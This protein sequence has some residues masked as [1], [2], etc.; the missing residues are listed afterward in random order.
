[1]TRQSYLPTE[2]HWG[3]MFVNIIRQAGRGTTQ[4]SIDLARFHEVEPMDMLTLMPP[5]RVSRAVVLG[6]ARRVPCPRLGENTMLLSDELV[7]TQG[8]NGRWF[9]AVSLRGCAALGR[10]LCTVQMFVRLSGNIFPCCRFGDAGGGVNVLLR[11][12]VVVGHEIGPMSPLQEWIT[13]E[14]MLKDADAEIVVVAT[15]TM[16]VTSHLSM[17]SKVYSVL[18]SIRWGHSFE[19]CVIPP[20]RSPTVSTAFGSLQMTLSGAAVPDHLQLSHAH[21][22]GLRELQQISM[23]STQQ[24]A[25]RGNSWS[26]KRSLAGIMDLFEQQAEATSAAVSPRAGIVEEEEA[27]TLTADVDSR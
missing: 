1:M 22:L 18:G 23:T 26:G 2:I 6:G 21:S 16:Y 10:D 19:Q 4:H 15:A 11:Y 14:G 8:A 9:V 27:P 12:P 7:V 5:S 25:G 20:K 24:S 3:C 17:R 13:P